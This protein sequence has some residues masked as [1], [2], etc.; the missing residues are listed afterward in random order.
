MPSLLIHSAGLFTTVQDAGRYGYQRYGMP[1]AGAMDPFSLRLANMLV[2]NEPGAACLEAT[3]VGPEI[4]FTDTT[5]VAVTGADMGLCINGITAAMNTTLT[6][7]KGDMLSFTG[8]VSGCRSYISFAGGIDVPEVMGSRSTY[9]RAA[10]GGFEGRALRNGDVVQL[11]KAHGKVK[12]KE[13]PEGA[14][15][16]YESS[17][18]IHI[19]SGPEA[20]RFEIEGLRSFLTA[21]YTVTD[22]SD[23]MGYRLDGEQIVHKPGGA[24][25]ISAGLSAGTIQVPGDGK[26]IVLMADRQTTGGYARIANVITADLTLVAQMKPGDAMRFREVTLDHARELLR[27]RYAAFEV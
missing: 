18:T 22:R 6:L 15:P 10:V 4:E 12:V 23:R 20:D 2:G 17:Q 5:T 27:Q 16:L 26:P 7:R 13:L 9:L 14:I 1:V 8:L 19:I 3:I 21:E 25:I 24:D 11:G